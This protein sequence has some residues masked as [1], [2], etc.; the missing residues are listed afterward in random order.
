M[1]DRATGETLKSCT[2]MIT[3]SNDFVTGVHDRMP[4]IL[5]PTDLASWLNDGGTALLRPTANDVLKRW[6]VSQ[7]VAMRLASSRVSRF[8]TVRR[9][10]SSSKY[11]GEHLLVLAADNEAGLVFSP[12]VQGAG[13]GERSALRGSLWWHV[14]GETINSQRSTAADAIPQREV[15]RT[16]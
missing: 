7:R 2:M 16:S 5:E 14:R 8:D 10:G 13:N 11:I 1:K 12:I 4:V 3:E 9:P 6:P 15:G